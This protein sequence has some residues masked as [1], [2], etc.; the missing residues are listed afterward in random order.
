V[1]NG[2]KNDLK[3]G[4]MRCNQVSKWRRQIATRGGDLLYNSEK[5]PS[6]CAPS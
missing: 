4:H 1:P 5:E 6:W 2:T 3:I